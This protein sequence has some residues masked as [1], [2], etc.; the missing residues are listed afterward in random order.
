[1]VLL[2][3]IKYASE[4]AQNSCFHSQPLLKS[5]PLHSGLLLYTHT[6]HRLRFHPFLCPH[7]STF[8]PKHCTQE[9]FPKHYKQKSE[10]EPYL[11]WDKTAQ[12]PP[13]EE[14]KSGYCPFPIPLGACALPYVAHDGCTT[15]SRPP[16]CR[17]RR[18]GTPAK[19][20]PAASEIGAVELAPAATSL[21]IQVSYCAER[22][23]QESRPLVAS[24]C[25]HH[26]S[27]PAPSQEE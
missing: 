1:M 10:N 4:A 24:A 22:L 13:N 16:Q 15:E 8:S 6:Q 21:Q 26:T 25:P 18:A 12:K 17:E 20:N 14:D 9:V 5:S 3:F 27:L 19:G 23:V 2:T 11:V 7:L